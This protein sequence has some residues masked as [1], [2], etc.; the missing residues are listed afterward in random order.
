[1]HRSGRLRRRNPVL[2]AIPVEYAHPA[3]RNRGCRFQ[4][5]HQTVKCRRGYKRVIVAVARKM[6][7]I[8]HAML[9]D[10][11]PCADH[12]IGYGGISVSHDC[13]GIRSA[14]PATPNAPVYASPWAT[15]ALHALRGSAQSFQLGDRQVPPEHGQAAIG[16]DHQAASVDVAERRRQ[17]RSDFRFLF[18]P[19]PGDGDRTE[20]DGRAAEFLKQG[21]TVVAVGVLDGNLVDR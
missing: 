21:E 3:V 12:G 6:P 17:A 1:M 2:R 14:L 4:A 15:R 18:D 5:W 20:N 16:C 7:R 9:R 10:S 8:I 19:A 13:Q 11:T